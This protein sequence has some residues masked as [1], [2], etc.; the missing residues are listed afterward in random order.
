MNLALSL[1]SIIVVVSF[2]ATS[3]VAIRRS[4]LGRDL[5]QRLAAV[6]HDGARPD[7][8]RVAAR[9]EVAAAA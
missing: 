3:S 4:Q 7:R 8:P 1:L 2:V 5:E 6:G 9:T